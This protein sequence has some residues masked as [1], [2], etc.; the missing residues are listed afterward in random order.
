MTPRTVE[1][2]VLVQAHVEDVWARVVTPAGFNH[3]MRPWVTMTM[4]RAARGLTVETVPLGRPV[5][6]AWL[7]LLGVIPFDYDRLV[8]VE[9]EPGR[10]FLERST[11]LSMR[12]WEHERI[13]TPTAGGTEVHDRIAFE[14]R[15]A[16]RP[17]SRLLAR[18]VDTFFQHR[19]RR[20][21]QRF[22]S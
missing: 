16:L 17:L 13:L 2:R 18:G 12:Q 6:R 14:P 1:K 19:Q 4:P 9:L 11:M 22:S 8:I 21:R 15:L 5:G 7:R 20:L 3:E 10:R